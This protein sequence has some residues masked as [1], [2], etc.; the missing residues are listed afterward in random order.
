MVALYPLPQ[1]KESSMTWL[2][3][4]LLSACIASIADHIFQCYRGKSK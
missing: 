3:I 2:I 4:V 1:D